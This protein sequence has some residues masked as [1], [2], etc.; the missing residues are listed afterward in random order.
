MFML[1]NVVEREIYTSVCDTYED[2]FNQ[3]KEEFEESGG[4]DYDGEIEDYYAYITDGNNHDNYDWKIVE[5]AK[6]EK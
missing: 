3:M 1:I 6:K 5:I 2:A 4:S